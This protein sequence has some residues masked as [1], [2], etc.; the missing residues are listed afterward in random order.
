MLARARSLAQEA[1]LTIA[2]ILSP[3]SL[4]T[5][6]ALRGETQEVLLFAPGQ[7]GLDADGLALSVNLEREENGN[8]TLFGQVLSTDQPLPPGGYARLTQQGRQ[9]EP[10]Q[11]PLDVHGGFALADIPAG[12]YQ[13]VVDLG[14]QRVIVPHLSL[15]QLES[16]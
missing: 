7:G 6:P 15:G 13:L 12:V 1:R 4:Q 3:T 8:C 11:A 5:A 2:R 10:T 14:G 9:T 16:A